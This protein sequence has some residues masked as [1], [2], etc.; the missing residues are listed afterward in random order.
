MNLRL[1]FFF[2]QQLNPL[3]TGSVGDKLAIV[4]L[5]SLF[6]PDSSLKEVP[7]MKFYL[8]Y[9]FTDINNKHYNDPRYYPIHAVEH[10]QK[11][12]TPQ[13]ND[14]SFVFPSSPLMSQP[15]VTAPHQFCNHTSVRKNCSKEF[16]ECIY[17]L[18][19]PLGSTVE[20]IIIDKGKSVGDLEVDHDEFTLFGKGCLTWRESTV[21]SR[22]LRNT[23]LMSSCHLIISDLV[24]INTQV[25]EQVSPHQ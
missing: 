11:L 5:N 9:D 23:S 10:D 25:G 8:P 22:S 21:Y 7:D 13:I 24:K 12:Y 15:E 14:I 19:I 2:L 16:C 20:L 17:K 4:E 6:S 18:D 3:N 1:R